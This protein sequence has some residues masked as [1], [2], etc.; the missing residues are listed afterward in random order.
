MSEMSWLG[1]MV[2]LGI[3]LGASVAS[4]HARHVQTLFSPPSTP[5]ARSAS[6]EDGRNA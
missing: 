4:Y 5:D 2:A 6:G 3:S 1:L